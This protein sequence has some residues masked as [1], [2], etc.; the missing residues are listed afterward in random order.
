MSRWL[1]LIVLMAYGTKI[2]EYPWTSLGKAES[3][4]VKIWQNDNRYSPQNV[5][6]CRPSK[7]EACFELHVCDY[8]WS[9]LRQGTAHYQGCLTFTPQLVHRFQDVFPRFHRKFIPGQYSGASSVHTRRPPAS[10]ESIEIQTGA[11]RHHQVVFVCVVG[12]LF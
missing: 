12:G 11:F 6:F 2:T 3:N 10:Q 7:G 1:I 8:V 9:Q 4:A 5:K